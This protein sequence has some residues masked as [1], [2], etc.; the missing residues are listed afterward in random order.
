[1]HKLITN[2]YHYYYYVSIYADSLHLLHIIEVNQES[3]C[4][5]TSESDKIEDGRFRC[6]VYWYLLLYL[7]W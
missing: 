3:W 2:D 6:K 1:M 5:V 4:G 7:D